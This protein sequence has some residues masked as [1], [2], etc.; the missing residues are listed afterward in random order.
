MQRRAAQGELWGWAK[1]WT[2]D[3]CHSAQGQWQVKGAQ[4]GWRQGLTRYLQK[5]LLALYLGSSQMPW[6]SFHKT[7]LWTIL[8]LLV[9][10]QLCSHIVPYTFSLL[11]NL[12]GSEPAHGVTLSFPPSLSLPSSI[13]FSTNE[14]SSCR[15]TFSPLPSPQTLFFCSFI[16][17]LMLIKLRT[18]EK[19]SPPFLERKNRTLTSSQEAGGCMFTNN[20]RKVIQSI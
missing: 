20:E 5:I 19:I 16:I 10:C 1:S 12:P 11:S 18:Q 2:M 13:L 7:S 3:G 9:F 17:N 6:L 14:A 8:L 15:D 4:C